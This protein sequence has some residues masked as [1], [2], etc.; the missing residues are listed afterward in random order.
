MEPL[1]QLDH[2]QARIEAELQLYHREQDGV[3]LDDM[4]PVDA[5]T[6]MVNADNPKE[7]LDRIQLWQEILTWI[8]QIREP[9]LFQDAPSPA[10]PPL[11]ELQARVQQNF[12]ETDLVTAEIVQKL[13]IWISE[14]RGAEL[15]EV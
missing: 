6:Y 4:S 3:A 13:N 5:Q 11:D 10:T 8:S 12:Q 9:L 15:S 14:L 2:L 1:E 7:N